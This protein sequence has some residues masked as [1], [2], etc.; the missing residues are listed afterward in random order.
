M[1]LKANNP[2]LKSWVEVP[3]NSDFPIQN[4]PFGVFTKGGGTPRVGVAIGNKVLDLKA[5]HSLGRDLQFRTWLMNPPVNSYL[6]VI[7]EVF[8][9]QGMNEIFFLGITV[10]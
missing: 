2:A 7:T 4:L 10:A 1:T 8:Y 9:F 3:S 6:E 5:L